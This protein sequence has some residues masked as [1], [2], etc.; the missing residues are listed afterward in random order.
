MVT[1]LR[2]HV[3]TTILA[4]VVAIAIFLGLLAMAD[5]FRTSGVYHVR[6]LVPTSASLANGANVSMA[7]VKVGKVTGIERRGYA[8]L[9]KMEISDKRV[10]PVP[11]DSHVDIRQRTP[12][13][14]N[15]VEITPG[16][17]TTHLTDDDVLPIDAAGDNVDVDQLLSVLQ[18]SARQR[19]RDLV[20]GLGEG[21]RGHGAQLNQVLGSAS[22]IVRDGGTIFVGLDRVR[23]QTAGLVQQLGRVSAAIGERGEAIRVTADRGLAALRALASRDDQLRATLRV[24]PSTLRQVHQTADTLKSASITAAPVVANLA[25]AMHDLRPAIADLQPAA[26]V[27]QATVDELGRASGPLTTTLNTLRQTAGPLGD[28]M[29]SL[30]SMLC[31][32]NP[33]VRYA[34]PYTRDVAAAVTSLGSAANAYDAI[35][36]TIRLTPILGENSLSGALPP[37]VQQA[38]F[39][40]SHT[41]LAG[42]LTPLSY[43]PYP[44]PNVLGTEVAPASGGIEGPAALAASGYKYPHVV[45]DC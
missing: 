12:I 6:A 22:Q 43:D 37:A 44:A 26:Q 34:A 9:V 14:E 25:G 28:A 33:V 24:L 7:G 10:V 27:A 3:V 2:A 45:A 1:K 41:G 11:A 15:Y 29:P 17:S 13:G 39:Q 38:T 5:V 32:I 19:A 42:Q 18:G 20:Q 4:L 36:H 21:L 40:L 16:T 35:G 31:Q 8:T 23:N 30:R